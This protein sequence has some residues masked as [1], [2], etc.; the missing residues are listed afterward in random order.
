[1]LKSLTI[2][3]ANHLFP[4]GNANYSKDYA[5]CARSTYLHY[6]L[7]MS[8]NYCMSYPALQLFVLLLF[9]HFLVLFCFYCKKDNYDLFNLY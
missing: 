9:I 1:M 6:E 7:G 8:R 3:I 5:A 2:I 4:K